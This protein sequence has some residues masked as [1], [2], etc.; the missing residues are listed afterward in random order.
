[1]VRGTWKKRDFAEPWSE[2]MYICFVVNSHA[3]STRIRPR[4]ETLL[5]VNKRASRAVNLCTPCTILLTHGI[6]AT[7]QERSRASHL[8]PCSIHRTIY[9]RLEKKPKK[10][11]CLPCAA[12]IASQFWHHSFSVGHCT[13]FTHGT[14]TGRIFFTFDIAHPPLVVWSHPYEYSRRVKVAPLG[15]IRAEHSQLYRAVIICLG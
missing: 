6:T 5:P 10:R 4:S 8:K 14:L 13:S 9:M 15:Q 3:P 1:M 11:Q 2:N 12:F 7:L